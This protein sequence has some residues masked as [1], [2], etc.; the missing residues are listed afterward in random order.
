MHR[1]IDLSKCSSSEHLSNS[2][3]LKRG[4]RGLFLFVEGLVDLLH[5]EC[6]FLG[7]RTQFLDLEIELFMLLVVFLDD[8]LGLENL[9]EECLLVDV[10]RDLPDLC[11]V[12]LRDEWPIL[13]L[14]MKVSLRLVVFAELRHMLLLD[15]L[16]CPLR[17]LEDVLSFLLN[18]FR[19]LMVGDLLMERIDLIL[20]VLQLGNGACSTVDHVMWLRHPVVLAVC[21]AV[22]L[23]PLMVLVRCVV[24]L[25]IHHHLALV[26][27]QGSL[28]LDV[29]VQV[30]LGV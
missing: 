1:Q 11:F 12:L 3:E 23:V 19:F 16:G 6:D 27:A 29:A 21:S 22:G 28:M 18:L 7:P 2:I 26:G 9:S 5:D 17:V 4:L 14:Q 15:D 20:G 8:M 13:H 25:Q 24:L 10:T 30:L